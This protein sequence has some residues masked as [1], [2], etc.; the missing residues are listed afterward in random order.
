MSVSRPV[1]YPNITSIPDQGSSSSGALGKISDPK[2]KAE[3]DQLFNDAI[4]DVQS[5]PDLNQIG[6]PLKFS[7]HATQRLN[8][9]QIELSDEM[10][11]KVSGAVNQAAVKGVDDTLVITEDAAFIINVKNRTVVTAMDR[12]SL[13]GNVFTNIDGAV[14][15]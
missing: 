11:S 13:D 2:Q 14:I 10:V 8:E 9:R 1:L 6:Q 7:A 3:F 4:K 12:N 15:V 5:T